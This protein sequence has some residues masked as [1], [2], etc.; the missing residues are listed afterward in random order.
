VLPPDESGTSPPATPQL[1]ES[2]VVSDTKRHVRLDARSTCASKCSPRLQT[3]GVSGSER[4]QRRSTVVGTLLCR[5]GQCMTNR[6][7][8]RWKNGFRRTTAGHI[9][10]LVA[11]MR[12]L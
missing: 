9:D 3:C 7:V 1:I 5:L 10:W 8:N 4:C 12:S 6:H 2:A 11:H